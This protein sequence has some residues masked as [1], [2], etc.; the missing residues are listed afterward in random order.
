[1]HGDARGVYGRARDN[2]LLTR[3]NLLMKYF[4]CLSGAHRDIPR[5]DDDSDGDDDDGDDDE[6]EEEEEEEDQEEE[7]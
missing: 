7:D 4:P 6:E 5:H 2:E 3:R 1:M